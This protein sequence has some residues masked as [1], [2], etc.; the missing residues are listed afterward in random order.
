MKEVLSFD[1]SKEKLNIWNG[2]V[3]KLDIQ[4]QKGIRGGNLIIGDDVVM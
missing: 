3:T 4:Q 2:K 1:S